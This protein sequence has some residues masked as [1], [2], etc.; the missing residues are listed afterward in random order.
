M[1]IPSKK[2]GETQTAQG[3][4]L[5]L[6]LDLTHGPH[7]SPGI[8]NDDHNHKQIK[9]DSTQLTLTY[10]LIYLTLNQYIG[11][12]LATT[13]Y[14]AVSNSSKVKV[15]VFIL[16]NVNS[17]LVRQPAASNGN[18]INAP[19]FSILLLSSVSSIVHH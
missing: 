13:R 17:Q 4:I 3:E 5:G 14:V 16:A 7:T 6:Q 15:K 2:I 9:S 1:Y 19:P 11:R 12:Q 10:I 8:F 18:M